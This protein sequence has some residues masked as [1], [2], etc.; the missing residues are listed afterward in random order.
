M[1]LK[2]QPKTKAALVPD[3]MYSAVLSNVTM[4]EN[5]YG[6]RVGFEFTLKGEGVEG[7]KVMRSTSPTLSARGKLAEVLSGLLG[8]ELTPA[9]LTTGV[10]ASKLIGCEC[11]VLVLQAK[12][13][14]GAMFSN[15]ER[16]IRAG[17]E[18]PARIACVSIGNQVSRQ[19]K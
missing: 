3:G 9:E 8:R 5:V 4:F 7:S 6:Q 13:K 10:D 12:G 17:T 11:E 2:P 18:L 14:G 16:I 15:V 19:H 1:L